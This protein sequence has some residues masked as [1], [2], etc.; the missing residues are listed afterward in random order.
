M[1]T[2]DRPGTELQATEAWANWHARWTSRRV[3]CDAPCTAIVPLALTYRV[4]GEDMSPSS[5]FTLP[6]RE[7]V[8]LDVVPGNRG[9]SE[10]GGMF[11]ILG[12]L[13]GIGGAMWL[14]SG[15]TKGSDLGPLVVLGVS[16]AFAGLGLGLL[17][18]SGTAVH[19]Q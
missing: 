16:V 4:V 19:F 5:S 2:L 12:A 3:V 14:A 9:A 11:T 1:V 15:G 18:S 7:R 13:G 8:R 17:L 6:A 10:A